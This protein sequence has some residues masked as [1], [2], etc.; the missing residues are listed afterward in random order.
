MISAGLIRSPAYIMVLE[1]YSLNPFVRNEAQID[2]EWLLFSGRL[3]LLH[4]KQTQICGE[5]WNS[6]ETLSE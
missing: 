4:V 6:F 5:L 1:K 3:A 2:T